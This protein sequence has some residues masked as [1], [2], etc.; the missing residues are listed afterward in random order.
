MAWWHRRLMRLGPDH[1]SGSESFMMMADLPLPW[2]AGSARRTPMGPRRGLGGTP[3]ASHRLA[4][5]AS[6]GLRICRHPPASL[7]SG[8]QS[9]GARAPESERLC[10]T[11]DV[12]KVTWRCRDH[13][14]LK[15]FKINFKSLFLAI[16]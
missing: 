4:P 15:C 3:G 11:M 10:S 2:P 13:K 5:G 16:N 1:V 14:Y 7:L 12:T 8:C 6:E 9:A